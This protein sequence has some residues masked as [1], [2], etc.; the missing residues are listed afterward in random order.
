MYEQNDKPL[1]TGDATVVF[2][3]LIAQMRCAMAGGRESTPPQSPDNVVN[4]ARTA[5]QPCFA[6]IC[7]RLL[8]PGSCV[9]GFDNL[10]E[11]TR[12]ADGGSACLVC[13]N[14]RSTLDVP[15]LYALLADQANLIAFNRIIWIAGRKLNE[16]CGV[17]PMMVQC[18]HRM[19]V[20]PK[21]WMGNAHSDQELQEARRMN[22]KAFRGIRELRR[23][24]W[25]FGL[26]PTGTRLRPNDTSTARAIEEIDSYL[27]CFDYVV[28]GNIDGCTLSVTRDHDLTRETPRLDRMVYTF[29]P[30]LKAAEWHANA[31]T[32]FAT[33]DQRAAA[34]RAILDDI[35]A[36]AA[37][38]HT[39]R[40][41]V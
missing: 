14:H 34:A 29:G 39:A 21:S 28:L 1:P 15:V 12:L 16:D 13:L 11:L 36:L 9:V 24:G 26:F 41:V 20:T 17:T 10:V 22:M 23:Q 3:D 7:R 37:N 31:A 6:A 32:R 4:W 25:L 8:L 30:V 35:A 18:F 27:K 2:A 40:A 33:L 19:V 38:G 5:G